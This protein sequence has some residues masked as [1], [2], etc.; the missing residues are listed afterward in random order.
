MND[1]GMESLMKYI[2]LT[3]VLYL[4]GALFDIIE[5]ETDISQFRP[6]VTVVLCVYR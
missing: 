5:G 4:S 6:T 1:F 3:V 2:L